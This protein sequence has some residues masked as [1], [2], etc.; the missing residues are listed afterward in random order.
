MSRRQGASRIVRYETGV[1]QRALGALYAKTRD[2]K[3][4]DYHLKQVD[5]MISENGTIA[6]Y[7]FTLFNLDWIR[8]GEA[9][10]YGCDQT[11]QT[12]Y[13]IA[14]D[15]F[16]SQ[17]D[18]QPRTPAGALWHRV[19]DDILKQFQLVEENLR[20]A[21]NSFPNN[22]T[23]G[24][25]Y[26]GYDASLTAVWAHP[27]TGRSPEVWE[28]HGMVYDGPRHPGFKQLGDYLDRLANGIV[29][30]ADPITGNWWLVMGYP[31][32][33]ESSGSAMFVYSLL[34]GVR[35]GYLPK[36]DYV[37]AATKAYGYL[38]RTFVAPGADG[39]L[40]WNGTVSVCSLGPE[41]NG[42]YEYYISVSKAQNDLKGLAPFVMASLE[43]EAL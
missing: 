35:K 6:G 20:V 43:Y 22:S 42:T 7:N 27:P 18:A 12:K 3:Y 30:A 37:K 13:K 8:T 5:S 21:P 31:N 17:I 23:S 10:L 16:R 40:S 11:N 38:A 2:T 32:Y 39:T 36:K 1:F 41:S 19:T 24:L 9:V 26:H 34:R 28:C 29:H 4:R 14:L 15:T 25:L 33:I